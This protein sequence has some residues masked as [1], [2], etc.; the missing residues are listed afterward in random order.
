MNVSAKCEASS[1]AIWI[2]DMM[3][4]ALHEHLILGRLDPSQKSAL[5]FLH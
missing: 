3:V 1:E 2:G 5:N 4:F